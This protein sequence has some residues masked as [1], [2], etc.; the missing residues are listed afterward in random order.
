MVDNGENGIVAMT[1]ETHYPVILFL[2]CFPF[3]YYKR[4][5]L[6]VLQLGKGWVAGVLYWS[7]YCVVSISSERSPHAPLT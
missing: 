1:V 6:H 7:P 4:W 5:V 3:N 2:L